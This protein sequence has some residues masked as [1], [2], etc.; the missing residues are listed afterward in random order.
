MSRESTCFSNGES[1]SVCLEVLWLHGRSQPVRTRKCPRPRL[2]PALVFAGS[3]AC[4]AVGKP[5]HRSLENGH[6][7]A[8]LG[9]RH[10][11]YINIELK[12][13]IIFV[14]EVTSLKSIIVNVDDLVR[15]H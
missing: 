2:V 13:G 5:V 4:F 15:G 3:A 8:S 1:L 14:N 9:I 12:R 11:R 10:S 7:V 6:C